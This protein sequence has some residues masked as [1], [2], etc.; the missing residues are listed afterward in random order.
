MLALLRRFC[1][2][3]VYLVLRVFRSFGASKTSSRSVLPQR[4]EVQ[5][6]DQW[7][8]SEWDQGGGEWEPF[9]V[10]VVPHE[11]PADEPTTTPTEEPANVDLFSDMQPVFKKPT[12]VRLHMYA[13]IFY[14]SSPFFCL[15][16]LCRSVLLRE[17]RDQIM[18]TSTSSQFRM[19]HLQRYT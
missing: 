18:W 5:G 8:A 3:L 9:T 13:P 12:R 19:K 17:R 16:L 15:I 2:F 1:S 7:G 6:N 4:E 11:S 14:N 10:Q